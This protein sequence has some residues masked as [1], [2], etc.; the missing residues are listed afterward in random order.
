M[1]DSNLDDAPDPLDIALGQQIR[2]MRQ[3]RGLSQ[4]ALAERLGLTFQ[5]VQKYE[6]GT[7]RVSFSRL[8]AIARA[9]DCGV[10]DL[11]QAIEKGFAELSVAP[12]IMAHIRADGAADLLKAYSAIRAPQRRK[13]LLAL[14]R[15]LAEEEK[16]QASHTNG[17]G[18]GESNGAELIVTRRPS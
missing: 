16:R 4:Q 11:V 12:T 7:N 9:L 3:Q 6:K 14:A 17:S 10:G 13:A 5:Q 15:E 18:A 2:F 1:T 8:V